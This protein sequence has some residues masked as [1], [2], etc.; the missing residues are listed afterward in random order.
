MSSQ[1]PELHPRVSH[2]PCF[3]AELPSSQPALILGRGTQTSWSGTMAL[4]MVVGIFSKSEWR[5][6]KWRSVQ[7]ASNRFKLPW[8]A[9]LNRMTWR[10]GSAEWAWR[11]D[12][13]NLHSMWFR[14]LGKWFES[15]LSMLEPFRALRHAGLCQ[16]R[17]WW[18]Q[19]HVAKQVPQNLC[20]AATTTTTTHDRNNHNHKTWSFKVPWFSDVLC[21]F[22]L[23][24]FRGVVF[25]RILC[26][27]TNYAPIDA[28]ACKCLQSWCQS[29]GLTAKLNEAWDYRGSKG[30][31]ADR[32]TNIRWFRMSMEQLVRE[33]HGSTG[34]IMVMD[35]HSTLY[36]III[37]AISRHHAPRTAFQ[38]AVSRI[39]WSCSLQHASAG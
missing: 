3:T 32:E 36:R 1:V 7:N 10:L 15:K 25:F 30:P 24:R 20:Q 8:I 35:S 5:Y 16:N 22:R 12:I 31:W 9:Q 13:L 33:V 6:L 29:H 23:R 26:I 39:S 27:A 37:I 4:I 38:I 28:N 17:L 2:S 34:Y 11:W 19:V 14:Q 18:I 21:D